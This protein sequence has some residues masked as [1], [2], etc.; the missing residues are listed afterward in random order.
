MNVLVLTTEQNFVWTSMQEII[1]HIVETWVKATDAEVINVDELD[2]KTH[3]DKFMRADVLVVTAFNLNIHKSLKIAHEVFHF[4]GRRYFYLHNFSTIACWPFFQWDVNKYFSDS[5]VFVSSCLKDQN[6]LKK[7]FP[8]VNCLKIPFSL[9]FDEKTKRVNS[10][11]NDPF[12][13]IGRISRQKNLHQLI[14]AYSDFLK[15]NKSKRKLI[16]FGKEDDLGSPNMEMEGEGYL[17]ELQKIVK[18]LGLNEKVEFRGFVQREEIY[19]ELNEKNYILVIPSLHSDENFG[20]SAFKSLIDGKRCLLSDWGGHSDYRENFEKQVSFVRVKKSEWG[21]VTDHNDLVKALQDVVRLEGVEPH[22]PNYYSMDTII[23]QIKASL[24][25][26][27]DD[28]KLTASELSL[29]VFKAK[30]KYSEEPTSSKVFSNYEDPLSTAFFEGYGMQEEVQKSVVKRGF[31]INFPWVKKSGSQIEVLDP[32][33]GKKSFDYE[34]GPA[35]TSLGTMSYELLEV[36]LGY[37]AFYMG[38]SVKLSGKLFPDRCQTSISLLKERVEKYFRDNNL[39]EPQFADDYLNFKSV[40]V[41]TVNIVLFGGYLNRILESGTW[42][43]EKMRLWVISSK[44]KSTLVDLFHFKPE[45][46]AVIPRYALYS[47]N[48]AVVPDMDKAELIYAGRV[49]RVKNIKLLLCLASSLEMKLK[50]IGN[51]DEESH[52]YSGVFTKESFEGEVQELASTLSWKHKPEFI[53][54]MAHDEWPNQLGKN[55]VYISLSS[56]LSE[57]YAVS[58]AQAQ[59]KGCPVIL[60]DWG[61]HCDVKGSVLKIPMHMI[62]P[63]GEEEALAEQLCTFIKDHWFSKKIEAHEEPLNVPTEVIINELDQIRRDFCQKYG[64]Q[65][66]GLTKGMG[67]HFA[68][69]DEGFLLYN[70]WVKSLGNYGD[71]GTW[72]VLEKGSEIPEI[73]PPFGLMH[74]SDLARGENLK[75][76]CLGNKVILLFENEQVENA[77]KSL[78][79]DDRVITPYKK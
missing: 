17:A 21:P 69:S 67:A 66:L 41:G 65:V 43:F 33:K 1:P 10:E 34:D 44:V 61:G 24:S 37:N 18:E 49:S 12:V 35:Q 15:I 71:P 56:Y 14:A 4:S 40:E 64:S 23:S 39:G 42:P 48:E 38:D 55:S 26:P 7:S 76:L 47:K 58:V 27:L 70:K 62:L 16:F 31:Y 2:I 29:N 25:L 74:A 9:E 36:L 6:L 28:S 68:E 60:S 50:I 53:S 20:M 75:R 13:F 63:L 11:E 79:G 46:I 52:D 8:K 73:E 19:K 72:V 54:K 78:M 77:L 59:E 22:F 32:H 30:S 5:D 3:A 57:D 45:Q 51:Y